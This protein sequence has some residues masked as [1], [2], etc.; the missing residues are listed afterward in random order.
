MQSGTQRR[1]GPCSRV[2]V[3][4]ARHACASAA[5]GATRV[6]EAWGIW[7]RLQRVFAR[8]AG[9]RPCNGLLRRNGLTLALDMARRVHYTA[10]SRSQRESHNRRTVPSGTR[11]QR[12]TD[13]G[14]RY[15]QARRTR[16]RMIAC[17]RTSGTPRAESAGETPTPAV[18]DIGYPV[19]RPTAKRSARKCHSAPG[20]S[21]QCAREQATRDACKLS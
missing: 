8:S 11:D 3:T 12:R 1:H 16:A 5:Y 4:R 2:H 7:Q 15:R 14:R 6:R 20:D 17:E 13:S 9:A 10:D 21:R 19:V 18:R